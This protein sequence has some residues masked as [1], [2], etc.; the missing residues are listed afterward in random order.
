[1]ADFNFLEYIKQH[2]LS[3][4]TI[5]TNGVNIPQ[6]T[7][8]NIRNCFEIVFGANTPV[9][10][11]VAVNLV[12]DNAVPN[13]GYKIVSDTKGIT[14]YYSSTQGLTYA[15]ITIK[16]MIQETQGMV[17]LGEL[18]DYPSFEH[19]GVLYDISRNKVPTLETLYRIADTMFNLKYNQLQLYIEGLSFEYKSFEKHLSKECFVTVEEVEKLSAY[20]KARFIDL[21]P[22]QNTLGHM[23]RWLEIDDFKK[24]SNKEIEM[25][26]SLALKPTTIDPKKQESKDFIKTMTNDLLSA[27]DSEYYNVNLDET[28]GI[29]DVT[30]YSDWANYM[31]EICAKNNKK[32]LMWS[33]MIS[34][35][36]TLKD[37]LPKNAILL[38]WGYEDLHPF[39]TECEILQ[40]SGYEFWVCAGTSSWRS[41]SGRTDNMMKNADNAVANAKKYG[42]TGVMAT[43]WGDEGHWQSL[44]TALTGISYIGLTAWCGE[45]LSEKT[46][47]DY[48][49]EHVYQDKNKQIGEFFVKLG[50]IYK[51]DEMRFLNS[52]FLHLHFVMGVCSLAQK[53]VEI[54]KLLDW[55]LPT[56]TRY[57]EDGGTELLRQ[58]ND[59][60]TFNYTAQTAYLKECDKLL[61]KADMQC[62][63]K[64]IVEAEYTLT[65]KMIEV[66]FDI[67]NYVEQQEIITETTKKQMLTQLQKDL[68]DMIADFKK[69]WLL[70][71]KYSLLDESVK[72]F[73][74]IDQDI[75]SKL[76]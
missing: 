56:A 64:G 55:M 44:P 63:D 12:E 37:T 72:K 66:S 23:E 69:V 76:A 10:G 20:C 46:L 31:Q 9:D 75:T 58:L 70:R 51:L 71:N 52:N 59:R 6:D 33:D 24:L 8:E 53:Q 11:T 42:A 54:D 60:K 13:Q 74:A 2:N 27:Y 5:K 73:E 34:I 67:R 68:Q 4:D 38:N 50:N 7:N 1:M 43:D 18:S 29:D 47:G 62:A 32:M 28:F 25:F 22:N 26:F 57:K 16:N 19:R 21:V 65:M 35:Y 41:I 3:G 17:L 40:Q 14:V 30:D 45:K 15:F 48:L 36:P 61:E 39:N 49:S